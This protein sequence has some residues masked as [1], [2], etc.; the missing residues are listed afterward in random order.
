[1]ID[2][3]WEREMAPIYV[4]GR[5]DP[6]VFGRGRRTERITVQLTDEDGAG[7]LMM[8][9]EQQLYRLYERLREV[10]HPRI[11][12]AMPENNLPQEPVTIQ[13][14]QWRRLVVDHPTNLAMEYVPA[15]RTFTQEAF[16]EAVEQM[17]TGPINETV[18]ILTERQLR[19]LTEEVNE[20]MIRMAYEPQMIN[21]EVSIAEDPED[22]ESVLDFIKRE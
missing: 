8:Y 9:D 12:E 10:F 22:N 2:I 18:A 14:P 21:I 5:V 11:I 17:E 20:R 19:D 6:M 7:T 13:D 3:R 4:M 15:Q 1:M 16:R